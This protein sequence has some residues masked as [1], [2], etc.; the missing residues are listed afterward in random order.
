MG[1]DRR[2]VARTR[3]TLAADPGLLAGLTVHEGRITE[4]AVADALGRPFVEP[5]AALGL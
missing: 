4:P 3:D 1:E 5:A 2:P